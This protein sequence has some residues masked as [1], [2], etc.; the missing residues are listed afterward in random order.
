MFR[1]SGMFHVP[2]FIDARYDWLIS[3]DKDLS[4]TFRRRSI[5]GVVCLGASR[6][7]ALLH[8]Y[9]ERYRFFSVIA[10]QGKKCSMYR[11]SINV[12][13]IQIAFNL[14]LFN[15]WC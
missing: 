8:N 1:D 3:E 5:Q 2:G 6:A 14:S 10:T 13:Y 7:T 4:E 11:C 12:N 15:A 9:I